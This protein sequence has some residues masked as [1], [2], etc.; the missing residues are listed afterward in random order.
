[1]FDYDVFDFNLIFRLIGVNI[2]LYLLVGEIIYERVFL[3]FN[4]V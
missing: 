1:M 3:V 2:F 4:L